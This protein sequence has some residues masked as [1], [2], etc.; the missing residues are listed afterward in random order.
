MTPAETK[1]RVL[2]ASLMNIASELDE[3]GMKKEADE[4]DAVI[5]RLLQGHQRKTLEVAADVDRL[6]KLRLGD[7]SE[8]E[9]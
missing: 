3:R 1:A 7:L 8:W 6:A 5:S 4:I 9:V 2:A